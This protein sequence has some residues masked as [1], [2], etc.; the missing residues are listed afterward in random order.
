MGHAA[1]RRSSEDTVSLFS[2][3]TVL[4]VV[5]DSVAGS[6]VPVVD[7]V[8]IASHLL[9]E[10][11]INRILRAIKDTVVG[12]LVVEPASVLSVN[13]PVA[14]DVHVIEQGQ[15][16]VSLFSQTTVLEVV[17]DFVA[18]STVPVVDAV[19]I[20]SHLSVELAINRILLAI[21]DTVVGALVVEPASVLSVNRPVAPDVH[22]TEQ[23][24]VTVSLFS[25]T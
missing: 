9:V 4:E 22:V 21:K 12:A 18:G 6:T 3:T 19:P 24:Q 1:A 10:L 20:A 14:P 16:T 8:P 2:Q 23:G 5:V 15:V 13:R 7:A 11:A 17:V 25:Q